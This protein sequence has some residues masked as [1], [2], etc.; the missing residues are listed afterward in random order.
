MIKK[1]TNFFESNK[2]ISI[3]IIILILIAILNLFVDVNEYMGSISVNDTKCE[4]R[5]DVIF[6][7][8][9]GSSNKL[10]NLKCTIKGIDYYLANVPSDQCENIEDTDCS[11]TILVLIPASDIEAELKTYLSDIDVQSKTCNVGQHLKCIANLPQPTSEQ[12]IKECDGPFGLCDYKR[13]FIHDFYVQNITQANTDG[14]MPPNVYMFKG[15]NNPQFPTLSNSYPTMLNQNLSN[16]KAIPLLCGDAYQNVNFNVLKHYTGVSITESI[17][18]ATSIVGQNPDITIKLSFKTKNLIQG[19]DEQ[20]KPKLIATFNKYGD[21]DTKL[22][23][24][25]VSN[26][27]C[28]LK[29]GKSYSRVGLLDPLD[30]NILSFTP[31]FA[32]A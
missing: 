21:P 29:N 5:S 20:G 16:D 14:T 17:N 30:T 11:N 8:I 19:K 27:I 10:I 22:V 15:V 9:F 7:Q 32:V 25:G 31:I 3:V 1:I 12:S 4:Q 28:K 23:Y 6:N 24:V 26:K 13:F 2:L 18:D